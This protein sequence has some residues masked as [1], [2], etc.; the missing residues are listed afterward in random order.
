[1]SHST[2]H[3]AKSREIAESLVKSIPIAK[4][5]SFLLAVDESQCTALHHAAHF[6]RTDV[7]DYLCSC[8]PTGDDELILK[9]DSHGSTAL[10]FAGNR[11]IA[12]LLVK[13]VTSEKQKQFVFSVDENHR[14]ALLSAA[15]Y[16][17]D[18]VVEYICSLF[19]SS[20]D[21]L[22]LQK[23][24]YHGS[25]ALHYAK[26]RKI[27]KLLVESV[28]PERQKLF[29]LSADDQQRTALHQASYFGRADVV[30]YL[31]RLSITNDEL[32]LKRDGSG[33]TA[34]HY[35]KN[36]ETAKLLVESVSRERQS[37]FILLADHEMQFTALHVAARFGRTDVVEYLCTSHPTKK[38]LILKK[39]KHGST[40]L[41]CA[42][43]R[44][45]AELLINSLTLDEQ[46]DF[47]LA[48][49]QN[50][51]TALH[52]AVGI[53]LADVVQYLCTLSSIGDELI[54]K[55]NGDGQTGL[56]FAKNRKMVDILVE[57]ISQEKKE[58]FIL[59]IDKMQLTALHVATVYGRAEVVEYLCDIPQISIKLV[60]AQ[61]ANGSTVCHFIKDEISVE[62]LVASQYVDMLEILALEDNEGNTPILSLTALG[63]FDALKKLLEFMEETYTAEM[64]RLYMRNQNKYNQNILH[65]IALSPSHEEVYEALQDYIHHVDM[66]NMMYVDIYGNTPVH[67]IAA[68]YDTKIFADFM[69]HLP[70]SARQNIV[71][72]PNTQLT[73]CRKIIYQKAFDEHFYL[74]KVLCD[75]TNKTLGSKFGPMTFFFSQRFNEQLLKLEGLFKYDQKILKVLKYSLNE[76]SVVNSDIL[77]TERQVSVINLFIVNS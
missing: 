8:F 70:L 18:D 26:N 47:I 46:K 68:R 56:Y 45:T 4:Q 11:A 34:L 5:Q 27:A 23:D 74:H 71:E 58:E 44:D 15:H 59:S 20:N 22:I 50:E 13:S 72:V 17:R 30:Q 14:T 37:E 42:R 2:L 63:K 65:L 39:S 64:M 41:H 43:N 28:T 76:Y 61:A 75:K 16:G 12:E 19:P 33:G 52:V 69:L 29:L 77:L 57:S 51:G 36:I 10:H 60:L 7:V 32:T 35:A 48:T 55:K 9:K 40:A 31:C 1:M 49:G 38:E 21:E 6:G 53:G 62:K 25:T 73:N 3:K 66:K 67:Y 24:S 54:L